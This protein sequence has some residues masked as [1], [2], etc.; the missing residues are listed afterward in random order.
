[1][2]RSGLRHR[3]GAWQGSGQTADRRRPRSRR[4]QRGDQRAIDHHQRQQALLGAVRRHRRNTRHRPDAPAPFQA[5]HPFRRTARDRVSRHH[6]PLRP[7]GA[8]RPLRRLTVRFPLMPYSARPQ[9]AVHKRDQKRLRHMMTNE[10]FER[11]ES[12]VR[13]YSRS[14]P[15]RF[16]K[17]KGATIHDDTGRPYIDFLAGCSSLNYGH[18]DPDMQAALVEYVTQDGIAH[19]LDMFTEAKQAFL[20]AY[21][22]IILKPRGMDYKLMFT[23]PTGANAVEAALKL[24]RKITGR[25]N[26]IALT[27]GFH[28]MTL[29]APAATATASAR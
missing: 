14:F 17:A 24:A 8:A 20:A 23:G 16:G 18:N 3:K 10:I 28:G 7:R 13:S 27:N 26:V 21:E 2:F 15:K 25:T 22:D 11:R 19:G 29:G 12:E 5:R 4:M 6:R 1:L 9:G